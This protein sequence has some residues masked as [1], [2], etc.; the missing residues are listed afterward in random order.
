MGEFRLSEEAEAELDDVWLY[1]ARESGSIE[2]ATRAVE[3]ISGRFW[4]L[5]QHPNIGRKRDADLR[6]GLRSFVAGDYVIL[7]RIGRGEVV[8]IL[9]VIHS[10]Q[11]ITALLHEDNL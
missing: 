11:D 5:A 9:H 8:L 1:V 2:A 3:S 10:S 4:I 7:Y 6:P